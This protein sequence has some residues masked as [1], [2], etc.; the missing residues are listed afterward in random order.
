MKRKYDRIGVIGS[1]KLACSLTEWIAKRRDVEIVGVVVPSFKGWWSE[2]L[3][4]TANI[5]NIPIY[6]TIEELITNASPNILFSVNYWK[7]IKEDH[8][9]AIP[10]GILNIH[11]SYKLKYKGRYSTSWAI[12]NARKLN[13]W[14][15]GT[16]IYYINDRLDEGKIVDSRKCDILESDTAEILFNRVEDLSEIMFKE[17]FE[18][19]VSGK[20]KTFMSEDEECFFYDRFSNENLEIPFPISKEY[21]Y[22]FVRAWSFEGRPKP[23]IKYKEFKIHLSI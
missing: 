2:K 13:C 1:R 20:V 12:I 10:G 3:E 15:H 6:F 11:H 21:L 7:R 4:D 9:D 17:N 14:T 18:M 8:I 22:D 23:F 19:I 5:F 16:T